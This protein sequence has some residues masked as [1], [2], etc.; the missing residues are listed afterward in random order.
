MSGW[1]FG[2]AVLGLVTADYLFHK[3]PDLPEG[4]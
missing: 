4:T 3:H 2:D 1:S